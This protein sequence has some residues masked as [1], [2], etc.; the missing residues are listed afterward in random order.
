MARSSRRASAGRGHNSSDTKLFYCEPQLLIYVSMSTQ[1]RHSVAEVPLEVWQIIASFL[2]SEDVKKL[3]GINR[4]LS[5]LAMEERYRSV[6][7]GDLRDRQT[8]RALQQL[9]CV[10]CL[11]QF[12]LS[13]PSF[14]GTR[15]GRSMSASSNFALLLWRLL[16]HPTEGNSG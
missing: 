11:N 6:S 4:P 13:E 2:S 3:Y 15:R 14:L 8:I 12:V 7:I 9:A 16:Y 10:H 1:T 5:A